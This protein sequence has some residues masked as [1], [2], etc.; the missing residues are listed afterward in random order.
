MFPLQSK[1]SE[2]KQ[3]NYVF[4]SSKGERTF[5][6]KY[7]DIFVNDLNSIIESI[8]HILLHLLLGLS[9]IF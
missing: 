7:T 1:K 6:F 8:L 2:S 4:I 9:S 5:F 3:M